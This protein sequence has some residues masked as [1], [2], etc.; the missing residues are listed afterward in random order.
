MSITRLL[1]LVTFIC[2]GILSSSAQIT[3]NF[4]ADQTEGCGSV[5]VNFC[6]NSSSSAGSIV[7]WS[8]SLGGVSSTNECQGRIFGSAGSYEICL[9]VTDSDGN[10]ATL[11]EPNYI[12]VHPLP[13]PDFESPNPDGCIPH[14]ATFNYTGSS[15]NIS[16]FIWGVEGSAGVVINNGSAAPNAEST[17]SIADQY[18][19]SLTVT[20]ENG[21]VN[22]ISKDDYISTYEPTFVDAHAIETFKCEPPFSVEFVND[23]IQPNMMY[24]WNFGNGINF[25]G[26]TPPAVLYEDEGAYTI[27]VIGENADTDCRD[28]LV[29][30][31][32]INIGYV[33]D[34]TFTPDE[35]C[36]DLTVTFT[37][38]SAEAADNVS[39]DFGDGTPIST[40]ANP[41]HIYEDAGLYTVTLTREIA[42]CTASHIS[43]TEIEVFGLP[44]VAYNN[45]NTL[46]CSVPHA[47]GFTGTS[48]DE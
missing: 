36:E 5:Q 2:F 14:T 10:M 32:Y 23:N 44:D 4:T 28:T 15:N 31:N 26:D 47:V 18:T 1:L 37:D 45:D 42:G 3:V 29:L 24:T 19:I 41:S 21:C 7:A 11:C 38:G 43:T 46:G 13:E 35:G 34:F 22:F 48:A 17:Y 33:V 16:E 30:E 9:T 27:T 40:A 25:V 20:D 12:T 8:W 6:D 39:W